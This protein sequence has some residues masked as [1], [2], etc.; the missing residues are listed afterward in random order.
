MTILGGT[1]TMAAIW[2]LLGWTSL[3][4]SQHARLEAPVPPTLRPLHEGIVEVDWNDVAGADRYEL[5]FRNPSGWFQLHDQQAGI[6]TRFN[7]SLAI[8]SNLLS[9]SPVDAFRVR[10]GSCR[11]WSPWSIPTEQEST[12]GMEWEGMSLPLVE[13]QPNADIESWAVWSTSITA[14][15]STRQPGL[16]GFSIRDGLGA[17]S[18]D[19]S[20]DPGNQFGLLSALQSSQGITIELFAQKPFPGDFSLIVEEAETSSVTRL[21]T[22][23]AI[24]HNTSTGER[25]VWPSADL[26]LSAGQ[27]LTLAV[28]RFTEPPAMDPEQTIRPMSAV[29]AVFDE[30]PSEHTGETFSMLLRFSH[31][32]TIDA[33]GQGF[34]G[35]RVTG[36]YPTSVQRVDERFDLWRL[37]IVPDGRSSVHVRLVGAA[38]CTS[39][40]AICT[41]HRVPLSNQPTVTVAGAPI[42]PV[43]LGAP[44]HHSGLDY[45]AVRIALSEPMSMS[46]RTFRDQ[47]LNVGRGTVE[48][49]HRVD[50][51]SDLWEALVVPESSDDLLLTLN[52]ATGCVGGDSECLE[53]LRLSGSPSL[54]IPPATVHL[55]FDDGPSRVNTPIILDILRQHDA[56]ATFFVVGRSVVAFPEVIER[57]I[58]EGHTLG[59]HTW[60]HD[61]LLRLSEAEVLATLTRTQHAL[62]EHATPCFRPP[63]YRFNEETVRQA[64]SI[65]L[66][67]VLN[68]GET[69]DWRRPGAAVITANIISAARPNAILV[70]H[71]G[72]GDRGQTIQALEAALSYLSAQRYAF[73][74]VCR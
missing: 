65:G 73:E 59:N 58:S 45:V 13:S 34:Y 18:Q 19:R 50:G 54:T 37:Q 32:V 21:S 66:R 3:F 17:I 38:G 8:V 4:S 16:L 40:G 5:Q 53:L 39:D 28:T 26:E 9:D 14:E 7:G 46:A 36:G 71:D 68:T 72:G 70:L 64:A 10:A 57:I 56:R 47:A 62:G 74:P 42:T 15:E 24:R 29:S 48:R 61:D 20:G 31:P 25:F 1:A 12:Y 27:E 67:M 23:D 51:R 6:K 30:V 11:G 2:L 22:C 49:V 35:L 41:Q 33:D 55:T 43:F 52:P 63:N 69:A 60:A 44:E